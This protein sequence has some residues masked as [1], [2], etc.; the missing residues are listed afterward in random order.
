MLYSCL[1]LIIIHIRKLHQKKKIVNTYPQSVLKISIDKIE[2]FSIQFVTS[3]DKFVYQ[4]DGVYNGVMSSNLI[5]KTH[6]ISFG[7]KVG[8]N[9]RLSKD[10][11]V[12]IIDELVINSVKTEPE[13]VVVDTIK[14]EPKLLSSTKRKQLTK[15]RII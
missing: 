8:I 1:F 15:K 14:T 11:V 9:L 13:I 7:V 3:S 10:K 6:L 12:P 5:S 4:Q 2:G